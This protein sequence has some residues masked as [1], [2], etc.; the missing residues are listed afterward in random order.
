MS[1]NRANLFRNIRQARTEDNL[2]NLD[3]I[4]ETPT[5]SPQP[6]SE[7]SQPQPENK[8]PQSQPQRRRGRPATGKRSDPSWIGRTYY[9]RLETDLDVEDELLKLKRSGVEL[10]KSELVESLL[11]AWVKWRHGENIEIQLSEFSPRQKG[12]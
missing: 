11:A 9:I 5:I 4:Q 8:L 3:P 10:D 6:T 7:Q 12:D 1:Q 2:N